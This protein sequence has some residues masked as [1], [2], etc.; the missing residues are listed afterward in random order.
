MKK[1]SILNLNISSINDITKIEE[2]C[3]YIDLDLTNYSSEVINYFLKN[4]SNY[5]YSEIINNKK[6]YVY[7]DYEIFARGEHIIDLIYQNMPQ[8]LNE[9]AKAKYLYI[10]LGSLVG[11]DI[12]TDIEKNDDYSY[13]FQSTTDSI[14]GTLS[15]GKCSNISIVKIY[16]YLCKISNINCEIIKSKN[17][18][19]NKIIINNTTL[20]IDLYKDIPYI[21]SKF[22]TKYFS[23]YNDDIELDKTIGYIK[24]NYCEV[25]IDESLKELNFNKENILPSILNKTQNIMDIANIEPSCLS[26]I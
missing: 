17:D 25:L 14:W 15:K 26:I 3:K 20:I 11:Y 4:G 5:M 6:G 19:Y 12:N 21:Q 22:K 7:V 10:S 24:N 8:N 9:L 23:N 2:S 13:S 18:Y 1:Q 16:Y